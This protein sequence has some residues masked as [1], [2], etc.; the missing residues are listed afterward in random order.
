MRK[1]Y[2]PAK[3]LG[4]AFSLPALIYMI[5][6]IGVPTLQNFALSFKNVD[7]YTFAD[8]TKQGFV[9]LKNYF[10]LFAGGNSI[11]Q[12]SM[13]NTLVFTVFSILFQFVTGF[14]LAL[15]FNRKFTGSTFFR[16][17]TMISWLLPVTVVGLLFKFMFQVKGGIINQFLM[18]LGFVSEPVE[19]LLQS[20]SA[21]ASIVTA[22]IWIGIPFNMM[23]ITTGLTTIP[24]EIYESAK[25]DGAGKFVTLFKITVPMIKPAI[26]SVLTL[27]FIYTFKVFD[28]AWVMTKGGPVNATEL[29]STYAY[30]L[31]FEEFQ[32]SKAATAA[33]VLFLILFVV[34]IFYIK[35]IDDS[36]EM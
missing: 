23:L 3:Y 9:G 16:G 34:G 12:R 31:S 15:L 19:W 6:F 14:A 25:L 17:A 21:M 13:I 20:K 24:E 5:I 11:L 1:K 35:T 32:F 27:G 22:N 30:R 2:I 28:L 33:N 10:D 4:L 26:M 36:E 8:K 18:T 29:M 7:V